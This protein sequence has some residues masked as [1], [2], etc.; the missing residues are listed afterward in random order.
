MS[1]AY[2][3]SAGGSI[4]TPECGAFLLTPVNAVSLRSRPIVLSDKSELTFS[5]PDGVIVHGDGAFLGEL[6][7]GDR[8]AVKKSSR[9]AIFLAKGK[10]DFFRH[11][12]E[13]IN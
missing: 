9:R 2:S 10:Q 7:C 6:G 4:L 1:T 5:F 8:V 13:K 3:L 11:L 12:T